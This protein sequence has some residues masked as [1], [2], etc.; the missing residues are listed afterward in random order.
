VAEHSTLRVLVLCTGN[1]CRS[2]M[3]EGWLNHLYGHRVT[4]FSAGSR[5]AGYVHP[6]AVRVMAEVGV[7]LSTGQ[8]KPVE[9]FAGQPFDL[10]LTVCDSA[11]EACPIFPGPA[12]RVHYDFFDPAKATGSDDEVLAMFRRVRD[13]IRAWLAEVLGAP[14][15]ES[16]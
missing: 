4:A 12:R 11:A 8:S 1:S 3:A 15:G 9:Q 7:D 6:M 14:S 10:V 16:V 2:Q 5:P 13:E